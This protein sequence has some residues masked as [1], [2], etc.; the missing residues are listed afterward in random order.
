MFRM[1][2]DGAHDCLKKVAAGIGEVAAKIESSSV[3]DIDP[4]RRAKL[5][6]ALRKA[7]DEIVLISFPDPPRR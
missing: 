1:T 5:Y 6:K 7:A 4:A 2:N 3:H